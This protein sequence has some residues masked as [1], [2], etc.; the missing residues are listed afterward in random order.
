MHWGAKEDRIDDEKGE[1]G[2]REPSGGGESAIIII[3]N[4]CGVFVRCRKKCF[5]NTSETPDTT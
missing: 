2:I 1:I 4:G 5:A 3:W